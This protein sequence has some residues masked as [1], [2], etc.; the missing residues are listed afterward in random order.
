MGLKKQGRDFGDWNR[1]CHCLLRR[2]TPTGYSNKNGNNRKIASEWWMMGRGKERESLFLSF[3]PPP[4]IVPPFFP[5]S[6][7]PYP[8]DTKRHASHGGQR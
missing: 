5:S 8:Y 4:S 2:D 1:Q 3:S 6:Q 7:P